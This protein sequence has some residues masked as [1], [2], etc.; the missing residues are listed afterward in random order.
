MWVVKAT[1]EVCASYEVY[2]QKVALYDQP[3]WS[4]KYTSR[5]GLQ[6]EDALA[7]ERRALAA[8][9][10]VRAQGPPVQRIGRAR[11]LCLQSR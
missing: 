5:G 1:G 3:V 9:A 11:C 4:C 8:L 7:S 6:L 2:L 10:A